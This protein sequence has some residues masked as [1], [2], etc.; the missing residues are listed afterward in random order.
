MVTCIFDLRHARH[1]N[2]GQ[3]LFFKV[4]ALAVMGDAVILL[5]IGTPRPV[6]IRAMVAMAL[7]YAV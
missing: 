2:F 5:L 4:E 1:C 3:L 6:F 7:I